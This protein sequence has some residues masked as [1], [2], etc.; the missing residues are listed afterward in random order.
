MFCKL[1]LLLH[2]PL[3]WQMFFFLSVHSKICILINGYNVENY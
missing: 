1:V 2:L 3:V